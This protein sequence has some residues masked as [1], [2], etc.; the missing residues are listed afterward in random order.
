[1]SVNSW[2]LV[3]LLTKKIAKYL[4]SNQIS[5]SEFKTH[6][7]S[8][9]YLFICDVNWIKYKQTNKVHEKFNNPIGMFYLIRNKSW[10]CIS[11]ILMLLKVNL[12]WLWKMVSNL[13]NEN[14]LLRKYNNGDLKHSIFRGFFF[15]FFFF[16]KLLRPKF[17][18][19]SVCL[20]DWFKLQLISAT[21]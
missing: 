20:K 6:E 15:V 16:L 5:H 9:I 8:A 21:E 19:N 2:H 3:C 17:N 18:I 7:K 10:P 12:I 14:V 1:M 13:R 11:A 4:C